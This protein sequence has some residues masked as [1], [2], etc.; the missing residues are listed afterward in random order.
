MEKRF[1]LRDH[2][3][4]DYV[5]MLANGSRLSAIYHPT[6]KGNSLLMQ[7]SPLVDF[8]SAKE[9]IDYVVKYVQER[10]PGWIYAYEIEQTAAANARAHVEK[11]LRKEHP[12]VSVA[13]FDIA[14]EMLTKDVPE[15][16]ITGAEAFSAG[17]ACFAPGATPV[18][19][20]VVGDAKTALYSAR[21]PAPESSETYVVA[22]YRFPELLAPMARTVAA[23]SQK[24]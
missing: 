13:V 11:E 24:D 6:V 14:A 1:V 23:M 9:R 3:H 19:A 2:W 7:F 5:S 18:Q 10:T 12:E 16:S 17:Q 21:L 20:I 4:T 15:D 22:K 8:E